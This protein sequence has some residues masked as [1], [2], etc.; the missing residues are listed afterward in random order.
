MAELTLGS[1]FG[2]IF[3]GLA[4]MSSLIL[5]MVNET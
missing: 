2:L 4:D 1:L 3:G 5:S